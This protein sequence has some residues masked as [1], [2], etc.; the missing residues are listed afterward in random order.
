MLGCPHGTWCQFIITPVQKWCQN[1]I[2]M[3][4]GYFNYWPVSIT[5]K[6]FHPYA[7]LAYSHYH[8]NE[9]QVC[10][11]VPTGHDVSSS[12]TRS[13]VSTIFTISHQCITSSSI[14]QFLVR[15]RHGI[16]SGGHSNWLVF[17]FL[18]G[19]SKPFF[20]QNIVCT[21]RIYSNYFLKTE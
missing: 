17:L 13:M 11:D 12:N 1:A 6:W 3:N 2:K 21:F 19:V 14:H 20:F 10:W 15:C 7:S 9:F 8:K 18:D 16:Q 5:K 4:L